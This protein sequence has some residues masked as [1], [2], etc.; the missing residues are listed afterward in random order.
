MN[1]NIEYNTVSFQSKIDCNDETIQNNL[2]QTIV[3]SNGKRITDWFE[4]FISRIKEEI[5]NDPFSI[6]IKGCDLYEKVYIESVLNKD[7]GLV[8]H[9]KIEIVDEKWVNSNYTNL[10]TFLNFALS[11]NEKI[12]KEAIKPNIENIK[13]LRSN[14]VEIPVIATMSSG[15]STLLNALIGQN[16]LF[17]DTGAATATTCNIKVNNKI[18]NFVAQAID[19]DTILEESQTNISDF[20]KTWNSSANKNNYS[21]LRLN[22]EGPVEHLN[23]SS[24]EL[25]F[26]DT[27]GPNSA[28]YENHTKKTYE[29]LKD[30][31]K[32]PIVLYVLDP[33]KMDSKDDDNTLREISEV[34]KNNEQNLDRIIFIYNKIDREE[35]DTKPFREILPKI[36]KFLGKYDISN[37]KIFPLSAKYAKLA[38]LAN[39]LSRS[40]KNKLRG[41]RDDFLPEPKEDYPGYQLLEEVPLTS[42]QKQQ[43]QSR[44][45]I[46]EVDADLVYSGLAA[47]KLYIEDYITNHHQKKQYKD[48]MDI[49]QGTSNFIENKIRLEKH[50]LE[51]KTLAEQ[52]RNEEKYKKEIEKL[53]E[54]KTQALE[55]INKIELDKKFIQITG[56]KIDS[57][58]NRLK[59]KSGRKEDLNFTEANELVKEANKTILNLIVSIETDL[60]SKMND[61]GQSYLLK[62]K[63]EVVNKFELE[64]PSLKS[65]TFSAAL[66]NKINVLDF[67]NI[68]NYKTVKSETK[69]RQASKEVESK[70]WYKRLF[71]IKDTVTY[72]KEY[73]EKKE[74]IDGG[75]F[76]NEIINPISKSFRKIVKD[77]EVEF[78][79]TFRE[80][81]DSF[82]D[83]VIHSFDETINSVFQQSET[84]LSLTNEEKNNRLRKF[85]KITKAISIL[86]TPESNEEIYRKS[87]L[88]Y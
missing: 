85:D 42:Y 72:M 47:I 17:E 4:S 3:D 9:Q 43:L 2:K 34:L 61:E 51:E 55:A 27:P 59:N 23:S 33:E 41:F 81:N 79:N 54:K 70:L 24:L 80:Y 40:E 18:E 15:K 74:V 32:L 87:A 78:S 62:L 21:N 64:E 6:E 28:Q 44:I 84:S 35:L 71:G 8:D 20:L 46:S 52:K 50:R 83:L 66:L 86:K 73:Q 10:D 88:T 37:P 67:D 63:K 13:N 56:K 31:Q 1:I 45:E 57:K 76:Y 38:Q 53:K 26:I 5:N 30:N 82:K 49:A 77:S 75:K 58:F 25:N 7:D 16:F 36:R 19:N 39:N 14:K 22:L 11:S 69:Q 65:K 60:I 68:N 48:L 29:Y 12:V